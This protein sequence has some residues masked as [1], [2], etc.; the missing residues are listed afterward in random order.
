[1]GRR[2]REKEKGDKDEEREKE[3]NT[4]QRTNEGSAVLLNMPPSVFST[5]M[6]YP[7]RLWT[8]T[9]QSAAGRKIV[10][11]IHSILLRNCT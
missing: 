5:M 6:K 3:I 8:V 1:M 4:T 11:K 7:Q 10:D 9:R 2:R